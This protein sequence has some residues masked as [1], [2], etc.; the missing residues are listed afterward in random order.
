MTHPT[1]LIYLD[2]PDGAG[3]T[4]LAKYFVEKHDAHYVHLTRPPQG[5]AWA[6]HSSALCD[7]LRRSVYQLV[8]LDRNFLSHCIYNRLYHSGA[9]YPYAARHLDRLLYRYRALR[10]LCIAPV[11][12]IK[13]T[14]KRMVEERSEMY[15]TGMGKVAQAYL[16]LW[17]GDKG[18]MPHDV[19]S[20]DY[21]ELLTAQGGVSLLDDWH[22]YNVQ[23]VIEGE[24]T[25]AE[26][27]DILL[28]H[29]GARFTRDNDPDLRKICLSESY[30]LTGCPTKF[31]VCLVGDQLSVAPP[32]ESYP[33][34]YDDNSSQFL[35]RTLHQV[36][37][38]ETKIC[39]VNSDGFRSP[40]DEVLFNYA[41]RN[42]H[43]VIALG[44]LASKRLDKCRIL[45]TMVRHP[46]AAR[47]F[48][49][50]DD[51]YMHELRAALHP[52]KKSR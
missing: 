50:H 20:L 29:L 1:G 4:T 11:E 22:Q 5:E 45:H 35:A 26:Q 39:I 7:C 17:S 49:Y 27:A 42:A 38:D 25:L 47:Q 9:E 8:V 10:V 52:K 2:G 40:S 28:Q 16:D 21:T 31:S 6:V 15:T 41:V 30:N 32:T 48:S 14:H 12:Y 44:E 37:A 33:F 19:L 46:Q 51:G 13:S 43:R 34:L 23:E 24:T 18:L 36:G 3:K